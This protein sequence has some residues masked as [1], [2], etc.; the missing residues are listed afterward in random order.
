[1]AGQPKSGSSGTS[2]VS[3]SSGT[4][5]ASSGTSGTTGS[6]G[7][8]GS[9]GT[10]STATSGTSGTLRTSGTSGAYTASRNGRILGFSATNSS[11]IGGSTAITLV[12]SSLVAANILPS[13][14]VIECNFRATRTLQIGSWNMYVYINTTNSLTGATL[15]QQQTGFS[16]TQ[17]F[18]QNGILIRIFSNTFTCPASQLGLAF[19][20]A[21]SNNS[22]TWTASSAYYVI[23]ALKLDNA[24]GNARMSFY[25]IILYE[26]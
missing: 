25:E 22:G 15:V 20:N 21:T 11:Y 4:S 6:S 19:T 10:S 3:G 26:S 1:L 18:V 14:G 16:N 9:S 5:G 2:G 12:Q 13:F 24:G 8:R 7:T 17:L 23:F